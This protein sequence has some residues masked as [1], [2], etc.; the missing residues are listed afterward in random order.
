MND[1][2]KVPELNEAQRNII[3]GETPT[4]YVK[5]RPGRGGMSFSYV[6]VGYVIDQLNK[7]FN[8]AWDWDIEDQHIGKTQV[9][10]KGKLSVYFSP[11]VKITKS[12]FGGSQVK[13]DRDGN[14]L[15]V[16]DDLK[17]ASSDALKKAASMLGV[18]ADIYFPQMDRL[19]DKT[20]ETAKQAFSESV[21]ESVEETDLPF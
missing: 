16:A 17:A 4:K 5:S 20:E 13:K 12:S 14:A 1:I 19:E 21:S 7:A 3:K 10:V 9:W 15:D 6:E 8:L 18:A 11:E 2:T